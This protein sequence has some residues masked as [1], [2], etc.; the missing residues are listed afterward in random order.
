MVFLCSVCFVKTL[1][2]PL[3]ME[4]VR[5]SETLVSSSPH[6]DLSQKMNMDIVFKNLLSWFHVICYLLLLTVSI[7][8]K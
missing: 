1:F 7:T 5:S 3:K 2:S 8:E 4:E 6:C